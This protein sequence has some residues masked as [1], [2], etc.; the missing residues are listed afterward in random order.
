[1]RKALEKQINGVD[2]LQR[3]LDRQIDKV[4]DITTKEQA[5]K[6]IDLSKRLTAHKIYLKREM[7]YALHELDVDCIRH[8]SAPK[9]GISADLMYNEADEGR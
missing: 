3:E 7:I 4:L 2:R 6:L 1:M 8:K 9:T 5:R